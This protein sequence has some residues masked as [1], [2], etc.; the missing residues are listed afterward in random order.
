MQSEYWKS[1]GQRDEKKKPK[2]YSSNKT[3][4]ENAMAVAF[5]STKQNEK[6]LQNRQHPY[7]WHLYIYI[8]IYLVFIHFPSLWYWSR[9]CRAFLL[10][11]VPFKHFQAFAI[12][13]FL[14]VCFCFI[15]SSFFY[16]YCYCLLRLLY[17]HYFIVVD[18]LSLYFTFDQMLR[19]FPFRMSSP[20]TNH[21]YTPY[22]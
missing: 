8:Y 15:F 14:N 10:L 7:L 22:I 20:S 21:P 13:Y 3:R 6:K 11:L 12:W 18:F 9:I 1:G 5:G 16:C 17:R 19:F 4:N 2:N